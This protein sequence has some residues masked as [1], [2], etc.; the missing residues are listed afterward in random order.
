MVAAKLQR[1][2]YRFL[3]IASFILIFDTAVVHTIDDPFLVYAI[4]FDFMLVIPFLYWLF[5]MR[6]KGKSIAKILPF[7]LLGATAAW[8]AL[9]A[10][11]RGTY[12]HTVWQLEAA[13]IAVELA[14]VGYELRLAYRLIQRFRLTAKQEPNTG[15]ALRTAM[16]EGA[17]KGKLARFMLHDLLAVYYLLFSW[18]KQRTTG[19]TD[20]I[21]S[22]TYH[23]KTSQTLY[24]ALITKVILLEGLAMHLLLQQWSH[25]AAWIMTAAD[26]W[27]LALIWADSRASFLQPIKLDS[28][29]L[30]LR[31]G[32]R[33]QAD[34]PLAAIAAVRYSAE[35][36]PSKEE[37]RESAMPHLSTPNIRI[38][39][40]YPLLIEE[41]LFQPRTVSRIYLALDEPSEFVRAIEQMR[42]G[43]S[44]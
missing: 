27:L 4:L 17:G 30:K 12:W 21:I 32:L 20:S 25:W 11:Q 40:A 6:A 8:V 31:Y 13:L 34:V 36:H 1:F 28:S 42:E 19:S 7:P 39:L 23:R 44:C 16:Y 38:E 9:P 5:V 24:A 37:H 15:E 35:Y 10:T 22:F 29:Q 41:L 26:L 33:M 2:N 14:I 18:G 3:A 43:N